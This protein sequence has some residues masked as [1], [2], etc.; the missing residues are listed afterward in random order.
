MSLHVS[1]KVIINHNLLNQL[2]KS[3]VLAL[4]QTADAL[5]GE[6]KNSEVMPFDT[7]TM[8]NDS[9]FVDD[10]KAE[11]GEAS[12]VTSTPYARR[13][14]FHPEYNYQRTH[15]RAAGGRWFRYWLPGGTR[16]NFCSDT[17]AKIYR[18]LTKL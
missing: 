9:T 15:N 3:A 14:Y 17:F 10:S 16:Q 6:I 7:G 11:S 5:M 18:R 13:L 4:C 12:I 8:Q 1:S 2:S